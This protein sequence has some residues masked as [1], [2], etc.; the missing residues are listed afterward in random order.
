MLLLEYERQ[1]IKLKDGA[2]TRRSIYKLKTLQ[3]STDINYEFEAFQQNFNMNLTL[4]N[5]VSAPYIIQKGNISWIDTPYL[6]GED[7]IASSLEQYRHCIYTGFVNGNPKSIGVADGCDQ[8]GM[9][10]INQN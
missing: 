9:V 1:I 5:P 6:S 2:R 4:D 3:P 7:K 8:A 10:I